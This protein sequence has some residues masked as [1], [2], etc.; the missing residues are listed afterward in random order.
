MLAGLTFG[1]SSPRLV[2]WVVYLALILVYWLVYLTPS[3][4]YW[5]VYLASWLKFGICCGTPPKGHP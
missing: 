1:V 5:L 3:L 4:V 2:Y